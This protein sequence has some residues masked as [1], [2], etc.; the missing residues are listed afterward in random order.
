MHNTLCRMLCD[1]V[2]AEPPAKR[3]CTDALDVTYLLFNLGTENIPWT[4]HKYPVQFAQMAFA[5][6]AEDRVSRAKGDSIAAIAFAARRCYEAARGT[7]NPLCYATTMN[8]TSALFSWLLY[9]EPTPCMRKDATT[10]LLFMIRHYAWRAEHVRG[11]FWHIRQLLDILRNVV[12]APREDYIKTVEEE[13]EL[14][15]NRLENHADEH[16]QKRRKKLRALRRVR[17]FVR[18]DKDEERALG[19][20]GSDGETMA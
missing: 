7:E 1:R 9:G 15:E 16:E 13:L 11:S 10:A 3:A 14:C 5:G 12:K 8:D 17:Y 20:S 4:K 19:S 6:L 2:M 18:E